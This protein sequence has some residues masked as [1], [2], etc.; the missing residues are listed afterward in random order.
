MNILRFQHGTACDRLENGENR[1]CVHTSALTADVS[2][3][4]VVPFKWPIIRVVLFGPD[5]AIGKIGIY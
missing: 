4:P 1:F 5:A 2:L 3:T